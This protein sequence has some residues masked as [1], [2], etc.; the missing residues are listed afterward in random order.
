VRSAV[1][2]STSQ[3]TPWSPWSPWNPWSLCSAPSPSTLRLLA[4]ALRCAALRPSS[5]LIGS[6][7]CTAWGAGSK[8]PKAQPPKPKLGGIT[9]ID[10]GRLQQEEEVR[11]QLLAEKA[12][13]T[14]ERLELAI[15]RVSCG[16]RDASWVAGMNCDA[17]EAGGDAVAG[18]PGHRSANSCITSGFV[19]EFQLFIAR[20]RR[21]RSG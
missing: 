6:A 14:Q 9:A 21:S 12:R 1:L 7:P 11:A 15:K 8:R 3:H 16:A 5:L 4:A 13:L 10:L 20:P 18:R 17:E 19:D 2:T